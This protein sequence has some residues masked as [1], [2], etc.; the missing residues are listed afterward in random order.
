MTAKV[1]PDNKQQHENHSL[2]LVALDFISG[3][4]NKEDWI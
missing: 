1:R 3:H 2:Q 4:Q